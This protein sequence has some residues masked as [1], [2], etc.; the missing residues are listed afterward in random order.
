[1][2]SICCYE[3]VDEQELQSFI[4]EAFTIIDKSD[5][6]CIDLYKDGNA[7]ERVSSKPALIVI[8]RADITK[9]EYIAK[10]LDA[11]FKHS[12]PFVIITDCHTALLKE[13]LRYETLKREISV[14]RT[15]HEDAQSFLLNRYVTGDSAYEL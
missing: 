2:N 4:Q 8:K 1:M 13:L 5:T 12:N 15:F 3:H 9:D 7:L 10:R 6:Y 11:I 14:S